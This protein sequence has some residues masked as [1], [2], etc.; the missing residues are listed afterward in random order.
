MWEPCFEFLGETHV[1]LLFIVGPW[2]GLVINTMQFL[3]KNRSDLY[4]KTEV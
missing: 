1:Y 3:A 2:K 4:L